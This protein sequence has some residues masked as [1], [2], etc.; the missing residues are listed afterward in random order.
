MTPPGAQPHNITPNMEDYLK[1]IYHVQQE[2]G[3]VTTSLL[4][5]QLGGIK[6]G[7]VSGMLKK[8]AELNLV[9]HVPTGGCVSPIRARR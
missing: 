9:S 2:H 8:L 3:D 4:S 6:P 7:S 5:E 1:A